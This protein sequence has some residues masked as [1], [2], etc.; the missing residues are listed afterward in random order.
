V[1]LSAPA[2]VDVA[3]A[4]ASRPRPSRGVL[5][6]ILV[7][8][9]LA[10]IGWLWA[11]VLVLL[12]LGLVAVAAAGGDLTEGLW[13]GAGIGWQR[14]ILFAAGIGLTRTFLREFVTRGVTRRRLA[15]IATIALLVL[16]A[17]CGAV[18]SAG[19]AIEAVIFRWQGWTHVLPGGGSFTAGNLPRLA[20]EYTTLGAVYSLAGWLVGAAYVRYRWPVATPLIPVCLVPAA[21]VEVAT[22]HDTRNF[23]IGALGNPSLIVTLAVSVAVIALTAFLAGRVT[24]TL[25]LR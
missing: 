13:S 6:I 25:P 12:A 1:P 2:T 9:Y 8:G 24:R 3:P 19:Y 20:L 7:R 4:A 22:G 11:G 5:S 18:A 21:I 23:D 17:I 15:E 16:A 14:W 10:W